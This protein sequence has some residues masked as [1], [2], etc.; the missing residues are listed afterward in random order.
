MVGHG[1]PQL[2]AAG[3]ATGGL[4]GAAIGRKSKPQVAKAHKFATKDENSG[5]L[6]Y[7][8][9]RTPA[10]KFVSHANKLSVTHVSPRRNVSSKLA[11]YGRSHGRKLT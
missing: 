3:A 9:A 8:T 10:G 2:L 5:G 6:K 1:G 4:A 7:L 11:V